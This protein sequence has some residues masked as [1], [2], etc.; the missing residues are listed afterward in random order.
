MGRNTFAN[1]RMMWQNVVSQKYITEPLELRLLKQRLANVSCKCNRNYSRGSYEP[2]CDTLQTAQRS[3]D[4]G[5]QAERVISLDARSTFPE[6]YIKDALCPTCSMTLNL[7][8]GGTVKVLKD[9]ECE[10]TPSMFCSDKCIGYKDSA[11]ELPGILSPTQRKRSH[12]ERV[13]FRDVPYKRCME[14]KSKPLSGNG[15]V[16][17]EDFIDSI[18]PPLPTL[19]SVGKK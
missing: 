13:T 17:L 6:K 8:R 9:Q 19:I 18:R 4:C 15:C 10:T 5:I 3:K 1:L 12:P 2:S 7:L 14:V 11:W 16:C